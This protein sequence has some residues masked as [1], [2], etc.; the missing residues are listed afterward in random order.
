ML[1]FVWECKYIYFLSICKIFVLNLSIEKRAFARSRLLGVQK[2]GL[3]LIRQNIMKKFL[4][5]FATVGILASACKNETPATIYDLSS[6]G[7]LQALVDE[8]QVP[9]LQCKYVAPAEEQ[10]F[11]FTCQDT[12]FEITN[13]VN[14]T[15]IF[16]AASLSKPMFAYIVMKMVDNGELDLD[17]PI[18]EYTDI[19]RFA[20]KEMAGKLTPRIVLSHQTGLPNWAAGPSSDEWPTS[21]IEFKYPADSCFAYSGEGYA[22]LQRAVET[23]R[24]ASLDEIAKKEVFEPLGLEHTSYGWLDEYDTIA[25]P[26]FN[27]EGVNRGQGR[28]PRENCAYTLRTNATDYAKFL[29]ALMNGE[30][31]SEKIHKEMFTPQVHA[32]R[33]ADEHRDCDSTVFWCLGFGS[34]REDY[35]WHWGDNGNFK[36]LWLMHP[37]TKE[38][39]VYFTN[40]AH[41][42]DFLNVFLKNLTGEDLPLHDW[43]NN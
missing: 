26:G 14:E 9:V 8:H 11:L 28:H 15:S 21:T 7:Q 27:D 3:F 13:P 5:I 40:S 18:C 29:V 20:D 41:G 4:L 22:F 17:T 35:F 36:A 25:L 2:Y 31:L 33:Y 39:A 32:I 37:A 34:V 10:S 1:P 24:G 42:H 30:G 38:V 43:I 6:F 19:D 23:V 12:L 16:Q